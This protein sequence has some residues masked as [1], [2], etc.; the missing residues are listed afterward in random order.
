VRGHRAACHAEQHDHARLDHA[1]G[2]EQGQLGQQVGTGRQARRQLPDVDRSF[3][4]QLADR[5]RGSGEA[6]AG[7]QDLEQFLG[8]HVAIR[9]GKTLHGRHEPDQQAEHER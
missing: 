9:P 3:L 4:D 7:D 8:G 6:G 1:D 5:A 2:P